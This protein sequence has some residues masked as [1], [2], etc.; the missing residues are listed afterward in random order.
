MKNDGKKK[1]KKLNIKTIQSPF[2][3]DFQRVDL[4]FDESDELEAY[5]YLDYNC[6]DADTCSDGAGPPYSRDM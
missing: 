5:A 4:D 1:S 3:E 6:S 2:D